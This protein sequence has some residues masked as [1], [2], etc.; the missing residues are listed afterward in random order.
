[1]AVSRQSS[2][3]LQGLGSVASSRLSSGRLEGIGAQSS[4][5]NSL[6]GRAMEHSRAS[7]KVSTA[8][9]EQDLELLALKQKLREKEDT[10]AA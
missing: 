3:R 8:A 10:E 9:P 4:G 2:K 5:R 1:M 7:S 6:K